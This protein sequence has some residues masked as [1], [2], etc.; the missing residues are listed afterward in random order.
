MVD[1]STS[2]RCVFRP[3]G[4]ER[5]A[6]PS[7]NGGAFWKI[8]EEAILTLIFNQ[9]PPDQLP[10]VLTLNTTRFGNFQQEFKFNVY[11]ATILSYL[12]AEI[13]NVQERAH[14]VFESVAQC[15]ATLELQKQSLNNKSFVLK[16]VLEC[17]PEIATLNDRCVVTRVVTKSFE[18]G[19]NHVLK[20]FGGRDG[21]V[22]SWWRAF[23]FEG[24]MGETSK[25]QLQNLRCLLPRIERMVNN[26]VR[27][28]QDINMRVHVKIF[29]KI[30]VD[31]VR[32]FATAPATAPATVGEAEP[33]GPA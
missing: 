29:N 4:L 33:R 9:T 16:R 21:R 32:C 18:T 3:T 10:E 20:I 8:H 2:S 31:A 13:K 25:D 6:L 5:T 17:L 1:P 11:A 28:V 24:S 19:N 23:L 26:E 12:S 15:L 30:I 14:V 27:R 7:G 22:A